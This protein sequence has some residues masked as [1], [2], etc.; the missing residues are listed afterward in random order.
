MYHGVCFLCHLCYEFSFFIITKQLVYKLLHVV[1]SSTHSSFCLSF[2]SIQFFKEII[3][4]FI[5]RERGKEGQRERNSSV[6]LPLVHPLP[7]TWPE[8]QGCA[9]WESNWRPFDW[10]AHA[11]STELHTSWA[12]LVFFVCNVLVECRNIVSASEIHERKFRKGM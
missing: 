4:L 8:T 7:G 10:Q 6:W 11:Q 5:F 12:N 2:K 3:Y 9:D 1:S